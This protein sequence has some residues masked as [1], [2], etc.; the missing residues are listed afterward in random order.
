MNTLKDYVEKD[1]FV[2][3][4][5]LKAD[6]DYVAA[7]NQLEGE[8][9]GDRDDFKAGCTSKNKEDAKKYLEDIATEASREAK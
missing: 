3:K 8:N 2:A 9:G 1:S 7:I 4:Y 6:V 5:K